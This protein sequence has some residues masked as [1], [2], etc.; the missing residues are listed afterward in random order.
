M[1]RRSP[2]SMRHEHTTRRGKSQGRRGAYCITPE[3]AHLPDGVFKLMV[4]LS[5]FGSPR[6]PWVWPRQA[7]LV[8]KLGRSTR[9]VYRY[10]QAA[11]RCGVLRTHHRAFARAS[12]GYDLREWY[13]RQGY[14]ESAAIGPPEEARIKLPQEEV[15]IQGGHQQRPV[16]R[17]TPAASSHS[18]H[19]RRPVSS[20][21][22]MNMKEAGKGNGHGPALH[23][24]AEGTATDK[25]TATATAEA[26][27]E[28]RRRERKLREN[29]HGEKREIIPGGPAKA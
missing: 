8:A 27:R 9:A 5:E 24:H 6:R 21:P 1:H 4:T 10:T 25:A 12:L 28:G 15:S 2:P 26:W 23:T 13:T 20:E 19:Q 7:L 29:L 16:S 14:P 22:Q 18:G 17:W 11:I 3:I